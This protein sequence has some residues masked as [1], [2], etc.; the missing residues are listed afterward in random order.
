MDKEDKRLIENICN[1]ISEI[2]KGSLKSE[3]DLTKI[4]T[5][6][7]EVSKMIKDS[8]RELKGFVSDLQNAIYEIGTVVGEVSEGNFN[9][10]VDY[11]LL[12]GYMKPIGININRMISSIEKNISQLQ[13]RKKDL[14]SA[15]NT[16]AGVGNAIADIGKNLNEIGGMISSTIAELNMD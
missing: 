4:E 15:I 10:K 2:L 14:N 11:T 12:K 6:S 13:E 16:L 7:P 1:A 5:K 3:V 8:L 9:I